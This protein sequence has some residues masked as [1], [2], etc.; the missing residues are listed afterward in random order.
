M[1]WGV[2]GVGGRSQKFKNK[3]ANS[4]GNLQ[5]ECGKVRDK[6]KL[7]KN[8]NNNYNNKEKEMD[9]NTKRQQQPQPK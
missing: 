4:L 2:W 7:K 1:G 8:D 6:I 5:T 9:I 3:Y